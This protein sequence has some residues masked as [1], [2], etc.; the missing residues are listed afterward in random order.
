MNEVQTLFLWGSLGLHLIL[1]AVAYRACAYKKKSFSLTPAAALFGAF[2]WG[3]VLVL[4]PFWSIVS[5]TALFLQS[6]HFFLV[7]TSV[8]W[9]V[10]SAGEVLYW[11]LEQFTGAVRN[12]PQ[13]LFGYRLVKS[14]AI[15]FVYQVFWQ[16]VLV[17]S[18][19]WHQYLG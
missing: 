3:D 14:E 5:A 10:R 8:F 12:K 4:S 13:D 18:I 19:I 7:A 16:C 15:Y 17:L 11:F 2:V 1:T 6:W 9:I